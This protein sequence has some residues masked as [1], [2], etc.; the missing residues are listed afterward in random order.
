[1][2]AAASL[3]IAIILLDNIVS[4]PLRLYHQAFPAGRRRGGA[5]RLGQRRERKTSRA[6]RAGVQQ[7]GPQQAKHER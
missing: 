4:R 3:T 7:S 6:D 5:H 2:Q 1:M